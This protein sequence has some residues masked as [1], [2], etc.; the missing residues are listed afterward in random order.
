LSEKA[1]LFLCFKNVPYFLSF[2][3]KVVFTFADL[4]FVIT[5]CISSVGLFR[6]ILQIMTENI[7]I[8]IGV[9]EEKICTN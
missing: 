6:V 4:A 5:I 8:K 1:V 7:A 3:E 2:L 9:G